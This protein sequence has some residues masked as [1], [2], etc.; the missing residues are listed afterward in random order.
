V[1]PDTTTV[2][3]TV[4]SAIPAGLVTDIDPSGLKTRVP[5][6]AGTVPKL[7]A[8]TPVKLVPKIVTDVPPAKGPPDGLMAV[9]T[10]TLE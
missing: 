9:T 3:S 6:L 7:I 2:T 4:P 5:M 8:V 1:L 10:G